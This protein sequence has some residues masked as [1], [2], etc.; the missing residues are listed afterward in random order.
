M[1]EGPRK[2]V[3][4]PSQRSNGHG[5]SGAVFRFAPGTRRAALH[6]AGPMPTASQK[7][8]DAQGTALK[9]V[10]RVSEALR[11]ALLPRNFKDC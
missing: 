3:S 11:Q 8:Q 2:H 5:L 4:S 7:V 9:D 10:R 1:K 6:I